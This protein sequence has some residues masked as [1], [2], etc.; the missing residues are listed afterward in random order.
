[1]WR[2]FFSLFPYHKFFSVWYWSKQLLS[3]LL[4]SQAFP[5]T[6]PF[7]FV[8]LYTAHEDLTYSKD[9]I[10][11]SNYSINANGIVSSSRMKR[12]Y[13]SWMATSNSF[14]ERDRELVGVRVIFRG[15]FTALKVHRLII[16]SREISKTFCPVILYKRSI[17]KLVSTKCNI[18]KYS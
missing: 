17:F 16:L 4:I 8:N 9:N 1:M 15:L 18:K 12:K 2:K 10:S 5:I 13:N 14:V 7:V 6:M 11:A 3:F